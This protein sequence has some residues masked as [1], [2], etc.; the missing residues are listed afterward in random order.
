MKVESFLYVTHF[1]NI[2]CVLAYVVYVNIEYVWVL[3]IMNKFHDS[4]RI[5][6]IIFVHFFESYDL[7][8]YKDKQKQKNSVMES[9]RKH[10]LI[11]LFKI[12]NKICMST[13]ED[14]TIW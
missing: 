11:N 7:L 10:S 9:I 3:G 13:E 8:K 1:L 12:V 4:G 14:N 5:T 6:I 2:L